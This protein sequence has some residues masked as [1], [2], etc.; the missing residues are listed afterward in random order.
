MRR[1]ADELARV[2]KGRVARDLRLAVET[3]SHA[4]L[5]ITR[6]AYRTRGV[7]HTAARARALKP[8]GL[9]FAEYRHFVFD[10]RDADCHDCGTSRSVRRVVHAGRQLY[11]C[12][13]CQPELR[14]A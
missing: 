6:R 13:V 14:R 1:A 10:R 9:A 3:R 4:A 2:L 8:R 7:T 11:S 5:L 12:S